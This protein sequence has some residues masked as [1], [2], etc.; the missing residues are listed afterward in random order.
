LP[1]EQFA[2]LVLVAI[3]ACAVVRWWAGGR[4]TLGL[5][6]AAAAAWVVWRVP[7]P[8][9]AARDRWC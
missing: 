3:A 4:L 2:L 9:A 8:R 6:W 1:G 7:L 5:V